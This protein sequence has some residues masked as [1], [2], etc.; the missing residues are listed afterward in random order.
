MGTRAQ[1]DRCCPFVRVQISKSLADSWVYGNWSIECLILILKILYRYNVQ[2]WIDAHL[3]IFSHSSKENKFW[4]F[5]C[6]SLDWWS[7]CLPLFHCGVRSW[8]MGF[9]RRKANFFPSGVESHCKWRQDRKWWNCFSESVSSHL[10]L[11]FV[12]Y[13]A[14]FMLFD[15]VPVNIVKMYVLN[16]DPREDWMY[17]Q[18]ASTINKVI[19]IIIRRGRIISFVGC[20]W[21][22]LWK[23][24][25]TMVCRNFDKNA[26]L[27]KWGAIWWKFRRH[28]LE[29]NL[30]FNL[31]LKYIQRR[32]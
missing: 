13:N 6:T 32:L 24:L 22:N 14:W 26:F 5:L 7:S 3:C 30:I 12:F 18:R 9:V 19:I 2:G 16:E 8:R 29:V 11:F 28:T 25:C 10:E 31:T 27:W 4:G 23:P 21:Q 20:R 15:I 1:I 17:V